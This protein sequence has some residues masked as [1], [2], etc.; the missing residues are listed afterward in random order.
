MKSTV[1]SFQVYDSLDITVV[2]TP[3]SYSLTTSVLTQVQVE[4]FLAVVI[5]KRSIHKNGIKLLVVL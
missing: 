3:D 4:L 2:V 1:Q 5:T